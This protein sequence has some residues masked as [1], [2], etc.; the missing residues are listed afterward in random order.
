MNGRRERLTALC[1]AQPLR[2]CERREAAGV[3]GREGDYT[4]SPL[5]ASRVGGASW[6]GGASAPHA[7]SS[8]SDSGSSASIASRSRQTRSASSSS[9]D[10]NCAA[11]EPERIDARLEVIIIRLSKCRRSVCRARLYS[12]S[13]AGSENG[14]RR[15]W[16]I[17]GPT[18]RHSAALPTLPGIPRTRSPEYRANRRKGRR[19]NRG[20]A[21]ERGDKND[22][23]V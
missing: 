2:A 22:L 13:L 12:N 7:G 10:H 1:R 18:R 8:S 11:P 16:N 19:F 4:W 3:W 21:E 15:S 14:V 9:C 17:F 20:D 23:L 6:R 5:A